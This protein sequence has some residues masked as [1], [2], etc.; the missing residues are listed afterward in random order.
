MP[1]VRGREPLSPLQITGF[2]GGHFPAGTVADVND[3]NCITSEDEQDAVALVKRL[4]NRFDTV[5]VFGSQAASLRKDF[6]KVDPFLQTVAEVNGGLRG[7][8][9]NIFVGRYNV[10]LRPLRE[11][12]VIG[13][14]ARRTQ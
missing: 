10:T 7:F 1:I 11:F 9:G 3:V 5:L 13:H 14:A 4:A 8:R 6:E 12:N 2:L